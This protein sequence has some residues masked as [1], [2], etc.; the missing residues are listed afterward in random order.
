M[1]Q[2]RS[3]RRSRSEIGR[4][5]HRQFRAFSRERGHEMCRVAEVSDAGPMHP[6]VADRQRID[7][8][9][10]DRLPAFHYHTRKAFGPAD[11]LRRQTGRIVPPDDRSRP[12]VSIQSF[13]TLS[14]AKTLMWALAPR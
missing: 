2:S 10:G 11:Y 5:P 1:S 3:V 7:R 6:V 4:V 8:P 9:G 14:P 13:G 12:T